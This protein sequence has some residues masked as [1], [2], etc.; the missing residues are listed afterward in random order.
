MHQKETNMTGGEIQ[1]LVLTLGLRLLDRCSSPF[2]V[3][4]GSGV[5]L[6]TLIDLCKW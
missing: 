4:S 6:W 3:S 1:S 5:S 2:L